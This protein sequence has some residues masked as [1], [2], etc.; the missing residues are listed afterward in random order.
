[1]EHDLGGLNESNLLQ[2]IIKDL[3]L[4]DAKVSIDLDHDPL[5]PDPS[6]R[7]SSHVDHASRNRPPTGA[8]CRCCYHRSM[9][10]PAEGPVRT[11]DPILE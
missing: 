8:I 2:R 4:L 7:T 6:S 3:Q 10:D 11:T 5:D 9:S 1:M